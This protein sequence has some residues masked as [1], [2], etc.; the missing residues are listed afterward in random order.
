MKKT[1]TANIA[2]TVFHIEEDAY[3]QLQRYLA[4]IRANFSGSASAEEIMADIESRVAEL[5]TDLLKGRDVVTLADVQQV[6]GVMGRPEDF[7]GDSEGTEQPDRT[8]P[9]PP[10]P[11]KHKRLF[12]DPE[13]KWVGGVLSG[14]GHYIGMDPI[15]LRIALIVLF[16]FS[17]G[18]LIPIYILMW[19]LVPKA[20]TAAEKLEMRGE[21]VTVEN[22]KRV[23]EEGAEKFKQGGQRVANEAK[24]LGKDWAPKAKQW[25]NEAAHT[26]E[27]A[28]RGAAS[29]LGKLIGV[30]IILIAFS[31]ML[32]LITGVVGGTWSLWS[33]TWSSDDLGLLDL[34]GLLFASSAHAL[35][36]G[37]GVVILLLVPIIALFLAG[38]R[39]LINSRT[40]RWLGW[41]LAI[42][43]FSAIVPTVLVGMGLGMDLRHGNKVRIEEKI[44]QPF[45]DVLYLD[46]LADPD[47]TWSA[48]MSDNN[49]RWDRDFDGLHVQNGAISGAWGECDVEQSPDSLYHLLVMREARAHSTKVASVRAERIHYSY[50]QNGDVLLISPWLSWPDSDKLR[51]QYVRFTL[52]V[53]IG[54]SVY[55]RKGSAPIL[56]DIHNVTNTYDADMVDRK[57]TMTPEGLED[58]NA[59]REHHKRKHDDEKDTVPSDSVKH[60][61]VAATVWPG[62]PTNSAKGKQR[63]VSA[64]TPVTATPSESVQLPNL[65]GML[66]A[67]VSL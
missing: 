47:S 38:F 52:Q 19:I 31:L 56:D 12:R 63:T 7:A 2:G 66:N 21:P 39:L 11:R 3:E 51:A 8:P 15:W 27:R 60:S 54:K 1:V 10:L 18:S 43:W 32:G 23:F 49:D 46:A 5:F 14:L 53:P 36:F 17:V 65:F 50:V 4:G 35:W 20:E 59:P 13:D 57:W 6:Q 45:G 62:P 55:L 42:L 28:G 9:L 64:R 58:L 34:G 26:A 25:S 33:A 16:Y 40:P 24:D 29:V 22:I 37:I 61:P 67:I 48:E 41:T 30:V 44:Q